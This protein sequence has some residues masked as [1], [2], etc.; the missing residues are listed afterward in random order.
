[1]RLI[2]RKAVKLLKWMRKNDDGWRLPK[3]IE[4]EY[5]DYDYR[6]LEA[7]VRNGFVGTYYDPND[8]PERTENGDL[9]GVPRHRISDLG[10]WYLGHRVYDRWR[11]LRNWLSLAIALAAFVKS[12]FLC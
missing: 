4:A 6:S 1:M 3:D 12:F 10:F 5:E 11:E 2:S 8:L 9:V 7:L